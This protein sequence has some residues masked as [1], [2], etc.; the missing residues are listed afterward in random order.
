MAHGFADPPINDKSNNIFITIVP[1]DGFE[2]PKV[3]KWNRSDMHVRNHV[4]VV[5]SF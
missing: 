2:N 4:I 3:V 1:K 5:I